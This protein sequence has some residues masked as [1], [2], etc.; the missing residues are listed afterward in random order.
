[1][2]QLWLCLHN[3]CAKGST[4]LLHLRSL[5]GHVVQRCMELE[6]AL[7]E[8]A[9]L[10]ARL[11]R[12]LRPPRAPAAFLTRNNPSY[13]SSRPE[14]S[15]PCT[16]ASAPP[17]SLRGAESER[18]GGAG[19]CLSAV[20][21]AAH[22]EVASPSRTALPAPAYS[23]AERPAH[24]RVR[25]SRPLPAHATAAPSTTASGLS[26][27]SPSQQSAHAGALSTARVAATGPAKR[28]AATGP[29]QWLLAGAE[30]VSAA[31]EHC[32]RRLLVPRAAGSRKHSQ[33][34]A[35]GPAAAPEFGEGERAPLGCCNPVTEGAGHVRT[36]RTGLGNAAHAQHAR[37]MPPL[38]RNGSEPA[39]ACSCA[40]S[41]SEP[42][43]S[44]PGSVRACLQRAVHALADEGEQLYA[45]SPHLS[46]QACGSMQGSEL[47]SGCHMPAAPVDML[48]AVAGAAAIGFEETWELRSVT[49]GGG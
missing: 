29:E 36:G 17:A 2:T 49:S 30:P 43:D 5:C 35:A 21:T 48:A 26:L 8:R 25:G 40:C 41:T 20:R 32:L 14:R 37:R 42:G 9:A 33:P 31:L 4:R 23:C 10:V 46:S 15:S 24:A 19:H 12:E 18:T 28:K 39:E 11:R 47:A 27:G 16:D 1:M 6:A 7:Q 38:Q 22:R 13:E 45:R 34:E 3:A 44:A